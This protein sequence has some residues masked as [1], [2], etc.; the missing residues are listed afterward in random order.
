[1]AYFI[2]IIWRSF[3]QSIPVTEQELLKERC[4]LTYMMDFHCTM[5]VTNYN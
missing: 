2:H 5:H 4:R 1:M 3:V